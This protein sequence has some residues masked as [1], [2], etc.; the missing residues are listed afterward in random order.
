MYVDP[1]RIIISVNEDESIQ[2]NN[3]LSQAEK[4]IVDRYIFLPVIRLALNR[5]KKIIMLTNTKFKQKNEKK[6]TTQ[7]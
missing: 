4:E 2:P 6:D 1:K 7:N 3:E 5:D